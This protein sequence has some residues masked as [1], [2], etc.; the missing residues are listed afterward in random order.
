MRL[1]PPRHK[2]FPR[3]RLTESGSRVGAQGGYNIRTAFLDLESFL[4][5]LKAIPLPEDLDLDRHGERILR[6]I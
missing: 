5:F 1:Y 4:F 3:S 2:R 6:F